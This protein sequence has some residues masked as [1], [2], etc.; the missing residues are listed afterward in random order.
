MNGKGIEVRGTHSPI[1]SER[2]ATL[3][4]VPLLALIRP[5]MQLPSLIV[6][7]PSWPAREREVPVLQ[8]C[9]VTEHS[10]RLSCKSR[11]PQGSTG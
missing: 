10:C 7:P 5:N 8:C 1:W 4:P 9:L 11:V 3:F 2:A 6:V